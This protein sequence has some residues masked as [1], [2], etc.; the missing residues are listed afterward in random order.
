LRILK[1][2]YSEYLLSISMNAGV[3]P[4]GRAYAV[5][6]HSPQASPLSGSEAVRLLYVNAHDFYNVIS[7]VLFAVKQKS[8]EFVAK[9]T[10]FS[11]VRWDQTW[12]RP[13]VWGPFKEVTFDSVAYSSD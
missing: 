5:A 10:G 8:V 7:V 1:A 6:L 4:E 9:K 12:S 2:C 11:P 13:A 3:D